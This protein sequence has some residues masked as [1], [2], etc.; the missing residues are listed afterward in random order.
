MLFA[1]D[2]L[3]RPIRLKFSERSSNASEG[4]DKSNSDAAESEAE[5]SEEQ[6]EES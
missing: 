6:H 1:Q 5:S 2:L 3:G 4:Q